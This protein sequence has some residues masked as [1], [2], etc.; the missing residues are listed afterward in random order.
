MIRTFQ[1]ELKKYRPWK[2]LKKELLKDMFPNIKIH[3]GH[4]SYYDLISVLVNSEGE[5]IALKDNQ[6]DT[7]SFMAFTEDSLLNRIADSYSEEE[8]LNAN[9]SDL[10]LPQHHLRTFMVGD[11]IKYLS[12]N[13]KV[14]SIKI[15]P[16]LFS[17][18]NFDKNLYFCEDVIFAPIFDTIT[19]KYMM[20]DPD[21]ALALL[22]IKTK[23]MERFGI[24]ITFHA[25]T[26]SDLSEEKESRQVTIKEK[27]E[28][29]AFCVPRLPIKRGS[30]SIYCVILN[31]D[32]EMEETAFIR[33][34]KTF[35]KHS[36]VIFLNSN[37][38]IK[39]GQLEQIVYDG[40]MI[41]TIFTPIIEWQRKKHQ[42]L[43]K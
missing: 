27:I 16:V 29:L 41:D 17:S 3:I 36:D 5:P 19:Q 35:D 22:S 34:Y 1:S 9:Y 25:I 30:A 26:N 39:T 12:T 4:L 28:E 40:E 2:I 37:L 32:N 14:K 23:D 42:D 15:N 10:C 13:T 20:T 11:L 43:W 8:I 24:E 7:K 21:Q 6:A 38:E 31:L 18:D 33:D